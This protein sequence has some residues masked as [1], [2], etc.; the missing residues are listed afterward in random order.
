MCATD[1]RIISKLE[2]RIIS[3]LEKRISNLEA[4]NQRY[5]KMIDGDK[6]EKQSAY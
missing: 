4:E 6:T 1:K 2:K 3:K 5:K